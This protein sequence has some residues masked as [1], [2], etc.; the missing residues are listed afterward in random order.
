MFEFKKHLEIKGL[1]EIAK[2]IEQMN[3]KVPS[4]FLESSETIRQTCLTIDKEDIVRA[5]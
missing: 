5:L 4:K 1:Q 3:R 2:I